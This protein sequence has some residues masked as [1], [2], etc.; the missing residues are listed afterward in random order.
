M[1]MANA[2]NRST[3]R[4]HG[5][6]IV[7]IG[8]GRFIYSERLGGGKATHCRLTSDPHR[9]NRPGICIGFSAQLQTA[10]IF[11]GTGACCSGS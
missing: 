2:I 1:V 3:A 9:H 11:M 10:R 8:S 5:R 7:A 4:R 6:R